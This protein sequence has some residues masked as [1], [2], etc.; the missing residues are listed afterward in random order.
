MRLKTGKKC[1]IR[2]SLLLMV[3][4]VAPSLAAASPPD[5]VTARMAADMRPGMGHPLRSPHAIWRNPEIIEALKLSDEQVARLKEADFIFRE[6]SMSLRA[7]RDTLR[8]QLERAFSAEAVD[9]AAVLQLAQ[10]IGALKGRRFVH[11]IAARLAFEKLLSAD[12]LKK[13]KTVLSRPHA[14]RGKDASRPQRFA[15]PNDAHPMA[16][17]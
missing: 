7:Q 3:I 5:D 8:L 4:F 17:R 16:D 9:E 10:K 1:I 2:V 15:A 6:K 12:Q 11:E 14:P 13:L